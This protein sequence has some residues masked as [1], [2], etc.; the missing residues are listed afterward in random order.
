MDKIKQIE[1]DGE[2]IYLRNSFLGWHTVYPIEIDGRI[3]WKN[4]IAGGSWI[5]FGITLIFIIFL[6]L[7]IFEVR[8]IINIANECLKSKPFSLLP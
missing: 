3:N 5:K 8:N 6:L 1:V 7:A 4:L 2:R